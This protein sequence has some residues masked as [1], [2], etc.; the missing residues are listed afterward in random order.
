M[1]TRYCCVNGCISN[2]TEEGVRFFS[3]PDNHSD[4]WL[5][6][7]KK[8]GWKP[9]P[10]SRI[11]SKHFAPRD[12]NGARLFPGVS[13]VENV[14]IA[15]NLLGKGSQILYYLFDYLIC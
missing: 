6:V 13:P 3:F 10:C 2:S 12:I 15:L 4:S 1:P 14:E 11:C 7:V 5:R 9:F 8:P